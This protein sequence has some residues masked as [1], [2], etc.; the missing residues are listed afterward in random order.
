MGSLVVSTLFMFNLCVGIIVAVTVIVFIFGMVMSRK[1]EAQAPVIVSFV[2]N[3][4]VIVVF[5]LLVAFGRQQA[6]A[7]Y[8]AGACVVLPFLA[9]F[10]TAKLSKRKREGDRMEDAWGGYQGQGT[11]LSDLDS[12][13][14]R[15]RLSQPLA[16]ASAAAADA[17]MFG[18]D[19]SLAA[20]S[21]GQPGL[22]PAVQ[23][24]GTLPGQV[25]AGAGASFSGSSQ[26]TGSF[27]PVSTFPQGTG[28]FAPV[29]AQGTGAF[30]PVGQD[31]FSTSL[32]ADLDKAFGQAYVAGEAQS[33]FGAPENLLGFDVPAPA[34]PRAD[35]TSASQ[36]SMSGA[37]D[38]G[39]A[40]QAGFSFPSAA[41]DVSGAQR[42]GG[43]GVASDP[44]ALNT[45]R[46]AT[47]DFS[48]GGAAR[49][50]SFGHPAACVASGK[51][52]NAQP[53][54]VVPGSLEPVS[55]RDLQ[56]RLA[57]RGGSVLAAGGMGGQSAS[58]PAQL[59]HAAQGSRRFAAVSPASASSPN[60]AA[61]PEPEWPHKTIL[62]DVDISS[63][64]S[65]AAHHGAPAAA[66]AQAGAQVPTGR[67]SSY[68]S[69]R[70]KAES[71]QGRGMYLVA[72]GLFDQA[73]GAAPD[74]AAWTATLLDQMACY[75]KAGR[76]AEA[77]N[78]AFELRRSGQLNA[79]QT[80]KVNAVIGLM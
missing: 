13:Q 22:N 15:M 60:F 62:S 20:F 9:Y 45:H 36:A 53:T 65:P 42:F 44:A 55:V 57:S 28:S 33:V 2:V 5:L 73:S 31:S 50:G 29:P 24:T 19:A 52:A 68:A 48:R 17:G 77:R 41:V 49:S 72:A 26:G 46:A 34:S 7:P 64:V 16:G 54:R 79:A 4:I 66:G 14:D 58:S 38:A 59:L 47:P 75:V 69:L 32:D 8:I 37:R 74:R 67:R 39:A 51:L 23:N 71:F 35:S 12:A 40:Q 80:V 56:T 21:A 27:A 61:P 76:S 30:V 25:V 43:R 6:A 3:A 10:V 1:P 11:S 63:A 78:V 18:Y 70:S